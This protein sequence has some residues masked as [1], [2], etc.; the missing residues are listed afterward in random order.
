MAGSIAVTCS[1]AFPQCAFTIAAAV[2]ETNLPLWFTHIKN[3][4]TH[5]SPAPP[6][7]SLNAALT[8]S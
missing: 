8:Y 6:E 5:D 2:V 7:A 4:H 3:N 1:K